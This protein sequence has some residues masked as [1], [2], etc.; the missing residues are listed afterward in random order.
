[1]VK[2]GVDEISEVKEMS[3]GTEKEEGSKTICFSA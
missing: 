3:R 2:R 1:M